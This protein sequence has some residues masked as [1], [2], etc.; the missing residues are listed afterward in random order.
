[1]PLDED[2]VGALACAFGGPNAPKPDVGLLVPL[3][4]QE[5][6]D[7]AQSRFGPDGKPYRRTLAFNSVVAELVKEQV[8]NGKST[9]TYKELPHILAAYPDARIVIAVPTIRLA[10]QAQ[11]RCEAILGQQVPIYRGFESKIDGVWGCHYHE[12]AT[13]ARKVGQDPYK[14]LCPD[15]PHQSECPLWAQ[16]N[17]RGSIWIV[18]HAQL[19]HGLK[20]FD[21][22]PPFDV[23]II[24]EDLTSTLLT[25]ETRALS[26]LANVQCGDTTREIVDQVHRAAT[27]AL[28]AGGRINILDLPRAK[29]L[30]SAAAALR[31]KLAVEV[32]RGVLPDA[33]AVARAETRLQVAGLL[34]DLIDAMAMTPGPQGEVAGCM[35]KKPKTGAPGVEIAVPRDIHPQFAS[36]MM[37]Q[38]LSA[39]AEPLLLQRSIPNLELRGASWKPYEDG[40]FVFVQG[41]KA[42]KNSL[43]DGDKLA[44]GGLEALEAVKTLAGRHQSVFLTSRKDAIEAMKAAGLPSNV[45]TSNFGAVEG[46]DA[47]AQCDAI[48]ILGRELPST[49]HLILQAEAAAGGFIDEELRRLDKSGK[50]QPTFGSKLTLN[51]TAKDGTQYTAHTHRYANKYLDAVRRLVTFSSP[52]QADRSRG[53]HRGPDNPV[54]IYD[55][56]GLKNVW[57]ID[58]VIHW[59]SLCG[60]LG[61]MMAHRFMLHPDASHG[62][63]RLLAALYPERFTKGAEAAREYRKRAKHDHGISVE[64]VLE[65]CTFRGGVVVN[66]TPPGARYGVPV[67]VD[68]KTAPEAETI[69]RQHPNI[70]DEF[71]IG[72]KARHTMRLSPEEETQHDDAHVTYKLATGP[73]ALDTRAAPARREGEEGCCPEELVCEDGAEVPLRPCTRQ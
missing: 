7:C 65:H 16:F 29:A 64:A 13:A 15:C 69:L 51:L 45:K 10:L 2:K 43:V 3:A 47:G 61:D 25:S 56:T 18:T 48:I 50:L 21:D 39:T 32:S 67:I 28:D 22:R 33:T 19:R 54:T 46:L 8:G 55:M 63:N 30:R 1:M 70:T 57:Q 24:D 59:R 49:E 71:K 9:T 20:P 11:A 27:A 35:V 14:T 62:K 66:I 53:Q 58:E 68:A 72:T 73:Q 44:S 52:E 23:V 6:V 42:T 41:P 34:D 40:K 12:Q 38:V 17:N 26:L 37:L 31:K 60:P 5:A 36:P 4:H